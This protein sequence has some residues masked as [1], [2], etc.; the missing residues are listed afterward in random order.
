MGYL[1]AFLLGLAIGGVTMEIVCY[2]SMEAKCTT[3]FGLR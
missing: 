3:G 1:L 2:N